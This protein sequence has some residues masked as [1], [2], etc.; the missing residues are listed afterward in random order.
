M[1]KSLRVGANSTLYYM[2][3]IFT[4][5]IILITQIMTINAQWNGANPITTTSNVGIGTSSPLTKLH[6][7]TLQGGNWGGANSIIW[8]GGRNDQFEGQYINFRNPSTGDASGMYWWSSDV[9]IGRY[10]N[11]ARWGIQE[12]HGSPYGT[13]YKSIITAYLADQNGYNNINRIA[14]APDGGSVGIGTSNVGNA[15]LKIYKSE[16]PEFEIA[17]AS[18][19]RLQMA[20]AKNAWDYAA[21]SKPGDVVFRKFG[22][23]HNILFSMPNDNNDGNS[24]IGFEDSYNGLWMKILNNKT[25]RIN[26]TVIATKMMV[27]TDVWS[28]YVFEPGYKLKSLSEIESFI[29]DNKHLPDVPSA[30]EVIDQGIDVAQMNAILLKK[31][32]ELTL[33]MIEQ[34]KTIQN[35]QTK[36]SELEK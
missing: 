17:D 8:V 36:I 5:A 15:T 12:M 2:K 6:V 18:N 35:L 4:I 7:T 9:L 29:I 20:I 13:N 26:G 10:K 32:E 27:K 31:I 23:N 3:K 22:A 25:V 34:N 28:D 11:E 24:Y 33:L 14:I 19:V 21:G 30:K 1:P 16:Y